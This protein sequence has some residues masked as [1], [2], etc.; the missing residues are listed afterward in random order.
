MAKFYQTPGGDTGLRLTAEDESLAPIP[1]G[2]TVIEFDAATNQAFIDSYNGKLVGFGY[3]DHSIVAGQVRRK[4]IVFP[5]A[6]DGAVKQERDDFD[7][8]VTAYLVEMQSYLAIADAA[9]AAQVRDQTKR[10]T[11]GIVRL[12]RLAKQLRQLQK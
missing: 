8:A 3:A 10:L 5:L 7:G 12:V 2:S 6:G 11:Q 4:G 9:T 1:V